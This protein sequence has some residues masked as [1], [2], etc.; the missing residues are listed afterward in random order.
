[1]RKNILVLAL[2]LFVT[3]CHTPFDETKCVVEGTLISD[4][5]PCMSAICEPGMGLWIETQDKS[6]VIDEYWYNVP[7]ELYVGATS[8]REGDYIKAYGTSR[9]YHEFGGKKFYEITIDSLS[10]LIP[11]EER[12]DSTEGTISGRLRIFPERQEINIGRYN[13]L[14]NCYT[15]D[16][17]T[18]CITICGMEFCYHE[19]FT[20]D[21]VEASGTI[22]Q[23]YNEY[24]TIHYEMD[25]KT[26]KKL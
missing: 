9:Y 10:I 20:Y 25:V 23:S 7:D 1:M 13:I 12:K 14:H 21:Q 18:N 17:I 19:D 24:G 2:I 16:S 15:Y 3:N 8:A 26:I 22:F 11:R 4:A 5:N 6:Y